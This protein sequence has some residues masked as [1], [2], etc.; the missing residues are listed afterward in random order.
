MVNLNG[1]SKKQAASVC[2]MLNLKCEFINYGYVD[3]QSINL[4]TKVNE[5]DEVKINLVN[6]Y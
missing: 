1:F 3:S 6:K 4:G 5:N 2:D